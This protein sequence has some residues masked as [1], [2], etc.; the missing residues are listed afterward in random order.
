MSNYDWDDNDRPLAFFIT[1]RTYGTWLHGDERGSVERHGRNVYGTDRIGLDP[2][3]SVS[4][5]RNMLAEPFLLDVPRRVCVEEAIRSVCSVR[6][7]GLSALN[8][9]TNHAHLVV[10][11]SADPKFMMNAFKANATR[12]LRERGLAR[13]DQ[14]VWCRGGSTRYLWKPV[15][16]ERAIDYTVNGQGDDLPDF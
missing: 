3:F 13:S 6:N 1:F 7:Y 5:D 8:V 9:R 12:E 10:S 14:K 15:Q 2:V 11:A 16:V 4:M